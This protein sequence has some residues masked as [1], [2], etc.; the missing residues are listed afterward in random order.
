MN[1]SLE[2]LLKHNALDEVIIEELYRKLFE[3]RDIQTFLML[4]YAIQELQYPA[5]FDALVAVLESDYPRLD[6]PQE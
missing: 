3:R 5:P 4:M 6:I 2:H 1:T